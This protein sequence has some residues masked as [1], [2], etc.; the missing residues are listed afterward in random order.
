MRREAYTE[1]HCAERRNTACPTSPSMLAST[2]RKHVHRYA[3][4][5][6][7]SRG[8]QGARAE[9]RMRNL[10]KPTYAS[11]SRGSKLAKR[12]S[13]YGFQVTL[14]D[15][16]GFGVV[17]SLPPSHSLTT[18]SDGHLLPLPTAR[19]ADREERRQE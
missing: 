1:S 18:R 4:S 12:V 17:A 5:A 13:L 15:G 3:A 14:S 10:R 6:L 8:V 19:R 2:S 7:A 16:S 9:M 11:G